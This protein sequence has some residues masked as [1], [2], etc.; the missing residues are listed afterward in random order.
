MRYFGTRTV[1]RAGKQ[2]E[3]SSRSSNPMLNKRFG[4]AIPCL[5]ASNRALRAMMLLDRKIASMSEACCM[6]FRNPAAPP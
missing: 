1:L 6:S 4:T 5:W 2:C 3:D